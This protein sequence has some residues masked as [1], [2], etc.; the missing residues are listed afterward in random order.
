[1]LILVVNL[2]KNT[3]T[4]VYL[5]DRLT[6]GSSELMKRH[7]GAE[8][9]ATANKV[10][11]KSAAAADETWFV[12]PDVTTGKATRFPDFLPS[13]M[14]LASAKRIELKTQYPKML[15]RVRALVQATPKRGE[16]AIPVDLG[17]AIAGLGATVVFAPWESATGVCVHPDGWVLTC[18]H[19]MPE[20]V[21]SHEVVLVA[22]TQSTEPVICDAACLYADEK[23]DL[24]LLKIQ[25]VRATTEQIA[26]T[27]AFPS[28]SL[29][30]LGTA[31]I[32]TKLICFG[33]PGREDL[34]TKQKRATKYPIVSVTGGKVVA[35]AEDL[36]DNSEIG[37]LTHNCW[38]YWGHSGAALLN[39]FD[40]TLV[41]LHS[42]W[43]GAT[44]TRHGIT[45]EALHAFLSDAAAS[46]KISIF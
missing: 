25:R 27:L 31:P 22:G 41:G 42:S 23:M 29:S 2:I 37:A 6:L 24:A 13:L 40:G 43:D 39:R 28:V 5:V 34:E 20:G 38:T 1:M 30:A 26:N 11:K 14:T 33:Q 19:C 7:A 21:G 3:Y 17:P 9:T 35:Y 10:S 15:A 36:L 12:R 16:V 32:N 4:T 8:L 46:L 44:G 45:L 18:A